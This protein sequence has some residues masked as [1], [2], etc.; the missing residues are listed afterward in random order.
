M[1]PI[2]RTLRQEKM[3]DLILKQNL[4]TIS[5]GLD[6]VRAYQFEVQFI[7]PTAVGDAA[8]GQKLT[9]AAK[10]V[11]AAGFTTEDIEVMR[12]NDKVFYPGRA[13]PDEITV[14]FDNF[15][16]QNGEVGAL[17]F[18]WFQHVFNPMS[19]EYNMGGQANGFKA[20]SMSILSLDGKGA[21]DYETKLLGVYPK[22][23]KTAEFNYATNEFHT[24]EVVFRY[25]FME[26]VS[27]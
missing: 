27:V 5:E 8:A 18:Q 2:Y 11:T 12:V 25:D 22:S 19:G 26:H 24:I 20:N 16:K 4:P 13:T 1:Q 9:L 23:W 10:Q 15:Y 14:T 7:L 17:L 6:S 21:I 3:S